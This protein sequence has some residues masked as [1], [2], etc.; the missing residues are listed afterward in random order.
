MLID[1]IPFLSRSVSGTVGIESLDVAISD[2]LNTQLKVTPYH[3]DG[4]EG[5]LVSGIK[6]SPDTD[7][8]DSSTNALYFVDYAHH[9]THA[10][11]HFFAKN[12]LIL[13]GSQVVYFLIVTPDSTKY[14]HL[15]SIF[16][17]EVESEVLV[18]EDSTTSA[19]GT[20]IPSFNRNRNSPITCDI[21]LYS[22]PTI[23]TNGNAL[24]RTIIGSGKQDGGLS[25][26]ESEFILKRNTK[27]LVRVTNNTVSDGWFDYSI[28]WYEHNDKN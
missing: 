16:S 26:G 27:Y 12:Y 15:V 6:Y 28:D 1:N 10:G 17:S 5:S 24:W 22:N 21:S 25:R 13:N 11:S 8:I 20:P 9:E 19:N 23:T 14:A 4:T 2:N 18:Y 7:G 3:S